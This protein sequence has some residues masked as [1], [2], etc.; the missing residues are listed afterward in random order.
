MIAFVWL[1][2]ASIHKADWYLA[3]EIGAIALEDVV[4]AYR[5]LNVKVTGRRTVHPRLALASQTNAITGIDTGRDLHRQ[6]LGVLPG[7]L[8]VQVAVREHDIF[9]RDG[10]NLYCEVPVSFVD[11]TLGGELDVP[12]LNGK[13]KL[14]VPAE[15]QSGKM[16]RL[17][18][19]GVTSVRGGA[20]GDLLCKVVIETPV[21]LSS[22]QKD[23]LRQFQD[24]LENGGDRHNPRKSSWF[25]GV[26]RFFD[27]K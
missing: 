14:K 2:R 15:T 16:F 4:F 24:S 23:L 20:P 10:T 8:Y 13:V 22:E 6:G 21:K 19:K 1:A 5:Y 27:T 12:T 26:K 9:Q 7:D 25:E 3:I 17:R 18:G 11:A